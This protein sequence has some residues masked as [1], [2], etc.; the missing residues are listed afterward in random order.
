MK[1][2]ML[3]QTHYDFISSTEQWTETTRMQKHH[4]ISPYEMSTIRSYLFCERNH[5]QLVLW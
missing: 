5:I 4:K 1:S 2:F 3:F